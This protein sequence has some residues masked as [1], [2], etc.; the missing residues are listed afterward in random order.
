MAR[1]PQFEWDDAHLSH[2]AEHGIS[3]KEAEE[4]LRNKPLD[5]EM[6]TRNGEERIVQVG[7]TD[8]GRVLVVVNTFRR[9]RVRVVTA[10]PAKSRL[11]RYWRSLR[12]KEGTSI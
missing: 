2:I 8:A 6:Q 9:E 3:A 1:S 7:E 10:F 5:L 4:V 12:P 11:L